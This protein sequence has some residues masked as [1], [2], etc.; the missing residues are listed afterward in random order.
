MANKTGPPGHFVS[1][2]TEKR[3]KVAGSLT[4][5]RKLNNISLS[6][7]CFDIPKYP[8]RAAKCMIIIR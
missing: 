1:I 4:S 5:W 6:Y 2:Y 8:I 7:N 3:I